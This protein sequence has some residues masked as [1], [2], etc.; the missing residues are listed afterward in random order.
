MSEGVSLASR[1]IPACGKVVTTGTMT[2]SRLPGS[3]VRV[4]E[5]ESQKELEQVIKDHSDLVNRIARRCARGIPR[6]DFS[7]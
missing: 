7:Q 1:L 5:L 3:T 6:Q 2:L 4:C